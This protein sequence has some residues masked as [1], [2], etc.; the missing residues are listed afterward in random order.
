MA[1]ASSRADSMPRYPGCPA[2][3]APIRR[4]I[5][6]YPWSP[7]VRTEEKT[8]ATYGGSGVRAN[9][10]DVIRCGSSGVVGGGLQLGDHDL[11]LPQHRLHGRLGA[12]GIR[13][14]EQLVE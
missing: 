12:S 10:W 8:T 11:A 5:A 9:G 13:V 3:S 6:A 2:A 7:S 4:D 14:A 1:S